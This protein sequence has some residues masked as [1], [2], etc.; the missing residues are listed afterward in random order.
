MA[1]LSEDEVKQLAIAEVDEWI[2]IAREDSKELMLHYYGTGTTEYLTVISGLENEEQ[3]QLRRKH[4]IPNDFLTE[5]LLRPID[6]IWSA[7]GGSIK[8]D[9]PDTS[10]QKFKDDLKNVGKGYSIR[11]YLK[12]VWKDKLISDPNGVVFVEVTANGDRAYLTQ[13][14]IFTIKNMKQSGIKAEYI[15]LKYHQFISK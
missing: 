14:S 11:E 10:L 7:K 9:L 6:A 3:L 15:T 5:N 13:K 1:V 2:E 8:I 12:S 4:A